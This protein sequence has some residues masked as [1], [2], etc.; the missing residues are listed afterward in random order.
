MVIPWRVYDNELKEK[1]LK[2]KEDD[3]EQREEEKISKK[4]ERE[5]INIP[6]YTWD[7]QLNQCFFTIMKSKK[8]R[9]KR[10]KV[11]WNGISSGTIWRMISRESW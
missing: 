5:A 2:K 4:N 6:K 1:D 8:K 7:D 9:I 3:E 11:K 10:R